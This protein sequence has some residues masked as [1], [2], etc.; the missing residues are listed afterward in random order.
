MNFAKV[1]WLPGSLDVLVLCG[2]LQGCTGG[3]KAPISLGEALAT[4][5]KALQTARRLPDRPRLAVILAGDLQPHA[6]VDDVL[7]VWRAM[8]SVG[9]WV[10]GVAGNHDRL[11]DAVDRTRAS[12]SLR[13]MNAHLL[14]ASVVVLDGLCVGG[15]SGTVGERLE[16]WQR[17]EC[18]YVA[19]VATVLRSGCDVLVLHDGPNVAATELAGWPAVRRAI[20]D[21]PQTLVV[22][23][24]D[25]WP[26]PLAR[27][28]N[29]TQ[30]VN[31]EARALVLRR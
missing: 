14:D 1:D 15:V 18:D 16:P 8:S 2:D 28:S 5:I 13:G 20:E 12:A 19:A 27:L 11:G 26:D 29:G 4:A 3:G 25:H 9:R 22:R 24:H 21:A 7:P 10:A 23:G 17:S 30:V 6:D 31:V